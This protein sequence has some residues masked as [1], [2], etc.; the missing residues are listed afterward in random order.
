MLT[1]V[2]RRWFAHNARSI[3]KDAYH[4]C[5]TKLKPMG[6]EQRGGRGRQGTQL[7]DDE[8]VALLLEWECVGE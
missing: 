7:L 3:V 2:E 5:R 6:L 8:T 1:C 4:C